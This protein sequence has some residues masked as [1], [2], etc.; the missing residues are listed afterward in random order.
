[1]GLDSVELLVEWEKYFNIQIP[2]L[3]AE[4][5]NTVQDAVNNISKHLNISE[6][7]SSIKD[8]IFNTIQST[9]IKLGYIQNKVN[10]SDYVANFIP[11]NN[12]E[13]WKKISNE[14]NLKIWPPTR[15]HDDNLLNRTVSKIF[16]IPKFNYNTLTF[17]QFTD[18]VCG[19]N[20]EKLIS[21]QG[22]K[23]KY[24][25]YIAV[26]GIT[27]DKIGIDIYEFESNKTFHGDFG[28]D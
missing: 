2:D 3:E 20:Y 6:E 27:V 7:N 17:G 22:I 8:D 16:W 28:I 13:T 4:K 11:D 21:N 12:N 19:Y 25:I 1:M 10:Y 26:M 18:A 14:L 23:S 24:E 5:I 9:F 15:G